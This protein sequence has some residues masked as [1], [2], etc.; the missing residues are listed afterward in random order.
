MTRHRSRQTRN[1]GPQHEHRANDREVPGG[2][3]QLGKTACTVRGQAQAARDAVWHTREVR[4]HVAGRSGVQSRRNAGRVSLHAWPVSGWLCPDSVGAA[5]GLRLRHDRRNPQEDGADGGRGHGRLFRPEH[6]Q[7]RLRHP[8][9]VRHRRRPPG[10]GRQSGAVRRPHE[11][12]RRLRRV[13]PRLGAGEDE[14]LH[15]H[16]RQLPARAGL[17]GC[18]R[19][20]PRQGSGIAAWQLHELV[21]T[22]GGAGH[23][24]LGAQVG[25]RADDR[26]DEVGS[27]QRARLEHDEHLHVRVVRGGCHARPGTCLRPVVGQVRDR[28]GPQ[29]RPRPGPVHRPA[30]L[31]DRLH[32]EPVRGSRQVPGPPPHVGQAVP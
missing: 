8:V 24:V 4:V 26:P 20:A 15:D 2:L 31:P 28:C 6:L 22:Y 17:A 23:P 13:D 10:S 19:G 14:L 1:R 7:R 30:R 29:G 21:S 27:E 16:G 25:L 9:H 3:W 12:G 32:R 11:H 18:C 5:D